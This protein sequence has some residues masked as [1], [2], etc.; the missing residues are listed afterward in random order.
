MWNLQMPH[1]PDTP[2]GQYRRWT[3]CSS[4]RSLDLDH[5]RLVVPLDSSSFPHPMCLS[6]KPVT[7]LTVSLL[8]GLGE[9][10]AAT[11]SSTL[12]LQGK[13]Y[14]SLRAAID[15]DIER[16]ETS[17]SHLQE[18]LT[19]LSEVVLQNRRGLDLPFPPARRA[20]CYLSWGVLLLYK[21]F[22]GC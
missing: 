18:S 4:S 16:I 22:S 7:A 11:E 14:D 17:I 8:L 6:T 5:D 10:R 20:M 13:K 3:I 12:V 1:S 2:A 15:L 21:P 19:S 9:S